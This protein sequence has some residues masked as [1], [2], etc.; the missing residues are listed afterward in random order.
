MTEEYMEFIVSEITQGASN[1][2]A[3]REIPMP[4]SENEN[5]AVVV[6]KVDIALSHPG[7]SDDNYAEVYTSLHERPE[8]NVVTRGAVGGI[9]YHRV[10][11]EAGT[12]EGTL[13]EY[14][15]WFGSLEY[16]ELYLPPVLVA[17]RAIYVGINSGGCSVVK[18]CNC[19]IGYTIR[20]ISRDAFI[21]ALVGSA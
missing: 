18:Q 6:H 14:A 20:K 10:V 13:S 16:T 8:S 19:R 3:E 7:T 1:T 17:R 2:Y 4:V 12:A 21:A 9:A 15:T 11:L 5:L